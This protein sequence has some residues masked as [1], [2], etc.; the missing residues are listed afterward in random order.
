MVYTIKFNEDKPPAYNQDTA[1]DVNKNKEIKKEKATTTSVNIRR[2]C[3]DG[4]VC[5]IICVIFV[6]IGI[7]TFNRS[8]ISLNRFLLPYNLS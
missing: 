2:E 3:G 8:F 6:A 7:S 1:S 4:I 5:A